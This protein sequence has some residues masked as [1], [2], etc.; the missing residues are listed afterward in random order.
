MRGLICLFCNKPEKNYR[1]ETGIDFICSSCVQLL[2][3]ADHAD[4]K[5]AHVK[6]IEKG[7]LSKARAIES[8]IKEEEHGQRKPKSKI[9]RRGR[10]SNRK[11]IIRPARIKKK[12]AK[13][14]E[15]KTASAF[16]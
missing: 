2:S 12:Q 6:A 9:D 8:F 15:T 5:R 7:Y 16:L 13:R 10:Y 4:L 3:D 11:R 1:P 14:V